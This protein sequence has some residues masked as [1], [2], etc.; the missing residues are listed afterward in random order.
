LFT[1]LIFFP[2]IKRLKTERIGTSEPFS[3]PHKKF[4][5]TK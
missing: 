2:S 3:P 4:K 5:I 1:S